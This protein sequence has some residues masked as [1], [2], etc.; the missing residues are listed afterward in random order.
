[1]E[2]ECHDTAANDSTLKKYSVF[3]RF[4]SRTFGRHRDTVR[5]KKKPTAASLFTSGTVKR[6][7]ADDSNKS[8]LDSSPKEAVNSQ[9]APQ[10]GPV[11]PLW[12][13]APPPA[14]QTALAIAREAN[15][16]EGYLSPKKING[17]S[18][19]TDKLSCEDDD[20]QS[21]ESD[22]QYIMAAI[23]ASAERYDE[24]IINYANGIYNLSMNLPK[25]ED[26]PSHLSYFVPPIPVDEDARIAEVKRYK[27]AF[28]RENKKALEKLIIAARSHFKLKG[29]T[30]SVMAEN[31]QLVACG[32]GMKRLR[33]ISRSSSLEG[34]TLLSES[35]VVI[36][37]AADDWRFENH[38]LVKDFPKIKFWA[39]A[40]L[41]TTTGRALGAFSIF[42]SMPRLEF[43]V[44]ERRKLQKYAEDVM[45]ILNN[46][47]EATRDSPNRYRGGFSSSFLEL[48][49]TTSMYSAEEFDIRSP[50]DKLS[51]FQRPFGST[52]VSQ[53]LPTYL[54]CEDTKIDCCA[55]VDIGKVF[56]LFAE[57]LSLNLGFETVILLEI[58][59][60]DT[61]SSD[62]MSFP[63]FSSQKT[64]ISVLSRFDVNAQNIQPPRLNK[65]VTMTALN[66]ENGVYTR[67]LFV[68]L[69]SQI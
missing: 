10:D 13:Y 14:S 69:W 22:D 26:Y 21:N 65:I 1:M 51:E 45:E 23:K 12:I 52:S 6:S 27:Y 54:N 5:Q 38:P 62:E 43:D 64:N 58:K 20:S 2:A 8:G 18:L 34:H 33:E 48:S 41:I 24:F 11:Q 40:P 68:S 4:L 32:A 56:E 47:L 37:S 55:T 31:M 17:A 9:Q 42:S 7:R 46:E 53:Q 67:Y 3:R 63:A 60:S 36:H 25:P 57:L 61:S 16:K 49:D 66:S 30:I 44:F 35:P 59:S 50:V 28:T 19:S 15:E 29:A 39:S